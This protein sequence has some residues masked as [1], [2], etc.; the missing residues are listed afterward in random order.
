MD[1]NEVSRF[2]EEIISCIRYVYPGYLTMYIFCFL[3][4]TTLR[5]TKAVLVKAIA[6]SY[7]FTVILSL[8]PL[9]TEI[10]ENAVLIA[11]AVIFPYIAYLFGRFRWVKCVLKGM[12]VNTTLWSNEMESLIGDDNCGW[13]VVYLKDD[14][15]VYEGSLGNRELEEGR[16]QFITLE[17]YYKYRLDKKGYPKE[18][19]IEDNEGKYEEKV[20]IFYDSIKRIEKRDTRGGGQ[21]SME[22]PEC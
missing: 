4:G 8:I 6:I 20:V 11:M 2:L 3:R 1:T 18:P 5:E 17:A 9:K 12:K 15:V 22:E 21:S 13:L 7:I 10:A 14:D 16:R 19:Y